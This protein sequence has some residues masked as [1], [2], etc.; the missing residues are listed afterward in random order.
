MDQ[1]VKQWV[2]LGIVLT[3]AVPQLVTGVW[4][5]LATSNWFQRF[6]GVDPRLVAAEPPYNA[7]LAT[8]AGAGFLATG[9]ALVA[10]AM[11]GRRSGVLVALVAYL[12][13]AVPHAVYHTANPAPGL[14]GV[15]DVTNVV[16]LFTGVVLAL[17]FGWGALQPARPKRENM[18]S[19]AAD[20]SSLSPSP[21]AGTST[22]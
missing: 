10:A 12:G 15:E 3:L 9:L 11:L 5:V 19:T 18:A 17:V 20:R 14:T 1:S 2:R 16:V 21:P 8:D 7:H 13:F 6:P 4:A 22:I